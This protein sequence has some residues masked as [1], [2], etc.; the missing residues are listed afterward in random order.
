[1]Q[2][3]WDERR[4]KLTL[5]S[6]SLLGGTTAGL[7]AATI[8]VNSSEKLLV[9]SS[10]AILGT[11]GGGMLLD[12]RASQLNDDWESLKKECSLSSRASSGPPPSLCRGS[13]TRRREIKFLA[14]GLKW[15]GMGGS[16]LNILRDISCCVF[17]PPSI[18]NGEAPVRSSYVK[19]PTLHQST[20]CNPD[21]QRWLNK[22][23]RNK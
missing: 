11:K 14:D 21:K 13:L 3:E 16:D 10:W 9:S 6:L 8:L 17:F 1:M 22:E 20:A 15:L 12:S 2:I 19:T 7:S 18:V 5:N 4:L 23:I